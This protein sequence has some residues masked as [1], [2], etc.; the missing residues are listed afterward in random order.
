MYEEV[1]CYIGHRTWVLVEIYA[2]GV[3]IGMFFTT[4]IKKCLLAIRNV[5]KMVQMDILVFIWSQICHIYVSFAQ[6]LIYK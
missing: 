5:H 3:W 1:I 4:K 6:I 2:L